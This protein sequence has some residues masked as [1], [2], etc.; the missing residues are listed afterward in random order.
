MVATE[1]IVGVSDPETGG[2]LVS[3]EQTHGAAHVNNQV[4]LDEVLGLGGVLNKDG[5]TH[6]VVGHIVL[7]AQVVHAMDGHSSIE[8]VMDGVVAHVRS[9]HCADHVEVDGVAAQ[10]E[11]LATVFQLNAIDPARG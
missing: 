4:V 9:V 2:G 6:S 8:G 11:G 1:D 3:V 5:V 7:H 10:N